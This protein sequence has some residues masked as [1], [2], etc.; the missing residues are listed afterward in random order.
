[1]NM[2]KR[3]GDLLRTIRWWGKGYLEEDNVDRFLDYY[4]AFEVLASIR[5]SRIIRIEL[6]D[7]LK[8]TL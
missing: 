3:K 4:I 2:K 6:R 1:M 5:G 7:S 8:T